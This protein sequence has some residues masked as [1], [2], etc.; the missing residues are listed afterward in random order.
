VTSEAARGSVGGGGRRRGGECGG[1]RKKNA[2]L[3][4]E[5]RVLVLLFF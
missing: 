4:Y 5:V 3:N 1:R 2:F